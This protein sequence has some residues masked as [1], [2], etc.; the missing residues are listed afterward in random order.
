MEIKKKGRG[1]KWWHKDKGCC[2]WAIWSLDLTFCDWSPKK[3]SY[4]VC[5]GNLVKR[6]WLSECLSWS[7]SSSAASSSYNYV[8]DQISSNPPQSHH[9]YLIRQTTT[10]TT[11]T[12]RCYH[13][14]ALKPLLSSSDKGRVNNFLASL[15]R[16]WHLFIEN[17]QNM[18]KKIQLRLRHGPRET[19]DMIIWKP[20]TNNVFWSLQ[21]RFRKH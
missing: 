6:R 17:C 4:A 1:Q 5:G 16:R 19:P 7:C 9:H 10:S 13:G 21:R 14:I 2:L 3:N 18:S 12:S 8:S 20:C 11:T 15:L